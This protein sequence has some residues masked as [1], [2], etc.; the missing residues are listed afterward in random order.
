MTLYITRHRVIHGEIGKTYAGGRP[1]LELE[2]GDEFEIDDS[3]DEGKATVAHLREHQAIALPVELQAPEEVHAQL[4]Q[5]AEE[6]A[7]LEERLRAAEAKLEQGRQTPL[8]SVEAAEAAAPSKV[9][10]SRK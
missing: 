6:K 3:T 8:S 4:A 9:S 10:G 1:T 7:A 2:P 5:L